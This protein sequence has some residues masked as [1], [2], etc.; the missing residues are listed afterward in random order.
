MSG[1]TKIIA[2]LLTAFALV[3]LGLSLFLGWSSLQTEAIAGCSAGGVVDC[4]LV[5]SSHWSR[6]LGIPVSFFGAAI[7][8]G[9][10]SLCWFAAKRPWGLAG[11]GLLFLSLSAAGAAVWFTSVQAL[12]LQSYCLY[13]L[14]VHACGLIVAG[15]TLMLIV[16][17]GGAEEVDYVQMGALLGVTEPSASTGRASQSVAVNRL[18]PLIAAGAAAVGLAVLMGGQVFFAPSSLVEETFAEGEDYLFEEEEPEFEMVTSDDDDLLKTVGEDKQFED[19]LFKEEVEPSVGLGGKSIAK[20]HYKGFPQAIGISDFPLLG[21]PEASLVHVEML[22]YT[23][24]HCRHMH[25][26]VHASLEEYG[27]KVAFLIHHVP[28]ST[29]CNPNVPRDRPG[30]KDSC[31]YARLAIGVWKLAPEKF[32]EFHNWLMEDEKPPSVVQARKRALSLVGEDI[33]L[34]DA[35]NAEIGRRIS[36]QCAALQRLKI[37]LPILFSTKGYIRGIPDSTEQWLSLIA[38][39]LDAAT[40]E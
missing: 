2:G 32:E 37:G 31:E 5:L 13:C 20:V 1:R 36:K 16:G 19:E 15:L 40:G 8:L 38:K 10:L 23:C 17:G 7:Y 3:A 4:D 9:I 27:G 35:L 33:L 21:D 24:R 34:D 28:L 26:F 11:S 22:D 18:F 12:L 14:G 39:K 29:K 25:P 6:W 30:K